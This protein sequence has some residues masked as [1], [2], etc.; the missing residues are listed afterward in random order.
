MI[1]KLTEDIIEQWNE[2]KLVKLIFLHKID[3][4]CQDDYNKQIIT[5]T[6]R[7]KKILYFG[8]ENETSALKGLKLLR[9]KLIK[10]KRKI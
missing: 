7:N 5:V 6:Q 9:D 2:N 4:I 8:F 3:N 10:N 1:K